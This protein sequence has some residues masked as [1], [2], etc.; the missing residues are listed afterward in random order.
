MHHPPKVRFLVASSPWPRR[1]AWLVGALALLQVGWFLSLNWKLSWQMALVGV[2]LLLALVWAW[3]RMQ[4]PTTGTLRWDG[5][6]WQWSGFVDSACL[7]QRHLDFQVL[8]LVSLHRPARRPTWVWL[9]RSHDPHQWL[10]LRRAVVH[11]TA[12][13][14][15]HRTQ[16]PVQANHAA[17]S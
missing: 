1:F 6:Q 8:M 2:S 14:Q 4:R 3:L 5:Q 16:G 12:P 10:A 11:A 17:I 7:L 9:Q 15:V 13:G